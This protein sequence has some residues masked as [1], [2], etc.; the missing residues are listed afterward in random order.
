MKNKAFG[1]SALVVAVFLSACGG[2]GG[3]GGEN[4]ANPSD[5]VPEVQ[6]PGFVTDATTGKVIFY[7]AKG[8]WQKYLGK[9]E[10]G[11]TL[12]EVMAFN[13]VRS[14]VNVYQFS[15]VQGTTVK[16]E[17]TQFQFTDA[18]CKIATSSSKV[19]LGV[20]L[21]SLREE[22]ISSRYLSF[23]GF[24]DSMNASYSG[25]AFFSEPDF[26]AF[27]Q[28]YKYLMVGKKGGLVNASRF[29]GVV[30]AKK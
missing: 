27:S 6:D 24:L 5:P 14:F 26:V 16:G 7:S 17:L 1:A 25:L 22:E 4:D 8:D 29:D 13:P 21:G 19:V 3:D 9:W 2:G 18:A 12:A 23:A 15:S 30:Y 20:S 11:C 10:S 28:G